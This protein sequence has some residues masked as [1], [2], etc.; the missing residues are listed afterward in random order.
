MRGKNKKRNK[1]RKEKKDGN[2]IGE[3]K[4]EKEKK[5]EIRIVVHNALKWKL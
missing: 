1:N 2:N 3:R 5:W 4:G